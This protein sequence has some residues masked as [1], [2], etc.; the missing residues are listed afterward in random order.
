MIITFT[1]QNYLKGHVC[2]NGHTDYFWGHN[3][4]SERPR[5]SI[6]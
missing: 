2:E 6:Y 1:V 4:K 3:K 5:E